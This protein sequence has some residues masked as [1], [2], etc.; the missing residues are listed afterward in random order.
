RRHPG[1]WL[2]AIGP[3]VACAIPDADERV[4]QALL[5]ELAP[6]QYTEGEAEQFRRSSLI[7]G[8][9]RALSA[10]RGACEQPGAVMLFVRDHYRRRPAS[11]RSVPNV[12]PYRAGG[13]ALSAAVEC[14][15]ALRVLTPRLPRPTSR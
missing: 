6:S 8:E 2:R 10:K 15:A 7:E 9:I 1:E 4:L 11:L 13:S 3:V 14:P 12:P 5:G